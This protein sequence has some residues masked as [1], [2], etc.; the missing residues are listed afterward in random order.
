MASF[1][2]QGAMLK[3]YTYLLVA[4][5]VTLLPRQAG[6][7]LFAPGNATESCSRIY[8]CGRKHS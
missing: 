5:D 3:R 1:S 2:F 8:R 4:A 7:Y 6:N